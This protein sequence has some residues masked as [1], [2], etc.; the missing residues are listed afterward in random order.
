MLGRLAKSLMAL[1][2]A[3]AF[4]VM[5][6]RW[7]QSVKDTMADAQAVDATVIATGIER[8]EDDTGG[9]TTV[10]FTPTVRYRFDYR[11]EGHTTDGIWPAATVSGERDWATA[12][13]EDYPVDATVTAHVPDGEPDRAFLVNERTYGPWIPMGIGGVLLVLSLYDLLRA[14]RPYQT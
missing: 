4:V 3:V 6:Y 5:G 7:Q 12:F 14:L 8:Q 9:Q 11:G 1:A 2:V 10:S 13:I